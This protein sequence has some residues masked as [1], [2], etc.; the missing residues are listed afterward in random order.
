M[1]NL[2]PYPKLS[3]WEIR[4][5]Q[6]RAENVMAA[7]PPVWPGGPWAKH[8]R[9]DNLRRLASEYGIHVRTL[10]RYLRRAT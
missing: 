8:R 6:A 4:E 10:Y 1:N 7:Y 2:G 9:H 5:L 3:D